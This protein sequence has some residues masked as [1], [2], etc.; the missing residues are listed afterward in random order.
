MLHMRAPHIRH[1]EREGLV[2]G[3]LFAAAVATSVCHLY[4]DLQAHASRT[5][6]WV[7]GLR[8]MDLSAHPKGPSRAFS[9][10]LAPFTT[11]LFPPHSHSASH[12]PFL[13][14]YA[15]GVYDRATRKLQVLPIR[16]GR[17]CRME[18][19]VRGL[20]YGPRAPAG[21]GSGAAAAPATT[22]EERLALS[23]R[24]VGSFGSTRRRRQMDAREEGI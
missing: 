7:T 20:D 21:S 3:T 15:V 5:I 2:I 19:R 8:N 9:H 1:Q 24:L 22:R 11:A 6:M 18:A 16:G 10:S 13:S 4:S 14:R 17:V 23:K 12:T